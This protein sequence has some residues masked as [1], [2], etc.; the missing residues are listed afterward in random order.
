MSNS[1]PVLSKE[2]INKLYYLDGMRGLMAINVIL[3]HFVCVYFPQMYFEISAKQSSGILNLFATTPLSATVNGNIA[4]MYFMALTGFLV[5]MSTFTKKSQG[6]GL[7]FKKSISRYTRLLPIIFIATLITYF[8]MVF[9]FLKH[10]SITDSSVNIPFLQGYCNFSPNIKSLLINIFIKPFLS[11][12][13]YIGPFWTIKYEFLGYIL[14]LFLAMTLKDNK[15][16]RFLYVGASML[17]M[18]L[19][20][21][22]FPLAD[23][24]YVVFIMG[25]FVADLKFNQNQTIL[26][27][28]YS[29]FLNSKLCLILCYV[30]GIYFSCCTMFKTPLYSWWF[31]IPV[32]NKSLLRG[33]GIAILIF[34]F[35]QTTKIQKALSW[36]PFLALGECSFE[37]Y[38]IHWPLMLSLEAYLFIVFRE[39]LSYNVSALL[40]FVITLPV[41]YLASFL[42]HFSV[43]K[44]NKMLKRIKIQNNKI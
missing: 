27:K 2:P 21:I 37:T 43:E 29:S 42:I 34:A 8:M 4:V 14:T 33:L 22:R 5:G 32:V 36:K 17:I 13:D 23:M 39:N 44:Y 35:T 11:G 7:F 10:L 1:K 16:R 26:S 12:S 41:I 18:V 3:C 30:I 40:S 9:N 6:I 24:H 15:Y 25:L 38:A 19:S 20:V 28:F 31:S